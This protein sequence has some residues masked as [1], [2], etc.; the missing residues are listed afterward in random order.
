MTE[1]RGGIRDA[2]SNG[3]PE[4]P[5]SAAL[6]G[7]AADRLKGEARSYLMAQAERALIG[8]GRGLGGVTVKLN[9]MAEGRS[10]GLARLALD[11]GRKIASGK[12]P[13]RGAV[14]IG[15]S[16]LKEAVTGSLKG[17][18]ERAGG[19]GGSGRKPTVIMEYVDVGVP[20]REV[21]ERWTRYED[22]AT[23]T[24]GVRDATEVSDTESHWKLKVFWSSRS[25][26]ARVTDQ[27]EEERVAW[28]SEGAKGTTKGVVTFHPLA[29][30]LTRV[31]LVLEYYPK[32]LFE[33]TGNLW[34]AQGRRARL[35]LKHFARHVSLRAATAEDTEDVEA[36]EDTEAAEGDAYDEDD[37]AYVDEYEGEDEDE[38]EEGV[39]DAEDAED[40]YEEPRSRR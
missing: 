24:R 9:D 40:A 13:L 11:G 22:F 4:N 18:L 26:T 1:T 17:A 10:P 28:T 30:R 20:V 19:K 3:A 33:R 35:D 36:A 2:A 16:R 7:P 38:D 37:D 25:W 39:E 5:L 31:L 27:V 8:V 12:G 14:E 23:F 29:E 6:R 32:G 34:R 21:Y 15:G